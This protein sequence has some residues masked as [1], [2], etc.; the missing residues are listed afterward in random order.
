[1]QHH[2]WFFMGGRDGGTAHIKKWR[3]LKLC[4]GLHP[5]EKIWIDAP[6]Y[7]TYTN[8]QQHNEQPHGS[9]TNT[10]STNINMFLIF[11]EGFYVDLFY[12]EIG[13]IIASQWHCYVRWWDYREELSTSLQ[14][15]AAIRTTS[16]RHVTKTTSWKPKREEGDKDNSWNTW[17]GWF[18]LLSESPS[19]KLY[20]QS[21]SSRHLPVWTGTIIHLAN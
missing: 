17:E 4:E 8:I 19:E 16:S 2:T 13:S 15:A 12:I 20:I 9:L 5:L 1:M 7:E 18:Q 14:V 10:H 6:A 21:I 3:L 11:C